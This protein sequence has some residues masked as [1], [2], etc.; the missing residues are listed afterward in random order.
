MLTTS[1]AAP[2]FGQSVALTDTIPVVNR[3]APT[4]IVSFYNGST[5]LGTAA[6]NA[7]GVATLEH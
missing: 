6:P 3:V 2:V 7:Y 5:L 1:N 4:G